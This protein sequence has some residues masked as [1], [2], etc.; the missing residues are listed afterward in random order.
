MLSI[1]RELIVSL[2]MNENVCGAS[3][4]PEA[5]DNNQ[6]TSNSFENQNHVMKHFTP[7]GLVIPKV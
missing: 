5:Q 7:F 2:H 6:Q 3:V 4:L 1:N